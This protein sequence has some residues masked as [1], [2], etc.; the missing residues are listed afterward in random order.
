MGY[1]PAR[2]HGAVARTGPAVAWR[3]GIAVTIA[4]TLALPHTGPIGDG[5]FAERLAWMIPVLAVRLGLVGLLVVAALGVRRRL[6]AAV[7]AA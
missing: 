4:A 6:S 7:P 1:I 3:L 2:D 5:R